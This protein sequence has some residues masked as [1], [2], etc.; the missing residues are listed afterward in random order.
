MTSA[1][2]FEAMIADPAF[3]RLASARRRLRIGLSAVALAMFFGFVLITSTP[4]GAAIA[5]IQ[6]G[7]IPLVMVIAVLNIVAVVVLTS[8]YVY[9]SNTVVDP[10]AASLQRAFRP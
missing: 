3:T 10:A 1:S 4:V 8:I 5:S 7:T 6:I 9:W 2:V